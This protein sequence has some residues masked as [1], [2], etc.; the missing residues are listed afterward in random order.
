MKIAR[1]LIAPAQ[2]GI[3]GRV[4]PCPVAMLLSKFQRFRHIFRAD[5]V[6]CGHSVC[7]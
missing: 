2:A 6:A 4:T 5:K 7:L 3:A 1:L